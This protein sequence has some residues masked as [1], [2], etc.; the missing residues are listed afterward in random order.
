VILGPIDQNQSHEGP[1]QPSRHPTGAREY[2][3]RA[4]RRLIRAPPRDGRV[5]GPFSSSMTVGHTQTARSC[6]RPG[7]RLDLI[8]AARHNSKE[9]A[10]PGQSQNTDSHARR[11]APQIPAG[12]WQ[13]KADPGGANAGQHR[14]VRP[15]Q[16]FPGFGRA[17]A[18]ARASKAAPDSTES[19]SPVAPSGDGLTRPILSPLVPLCYPVG[20]TG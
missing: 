6:P 20:R 13:A 18:E 4:A 12:P 1:F 8:G 9:S 10:A 19:G 2:R 3:A 15:G 17:I 16:R 5:R 11:V 7:S 14:G